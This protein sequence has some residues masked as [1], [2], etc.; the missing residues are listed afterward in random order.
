MQK[1]PMP[2]IVMSSL[3]PQGSDLALEALE[4]GAVDVLGKPYG[5]HSVALL[6]RQLAERLKT[7]VR[8]R[9]RPSAALAPC[10]KFEGPKGPS[11]IRGYRFHPRQLIVLGA[12][13]GGTEALRHV[14]ARLPGDLPPIAIV[15]HIPAGFS[16]TFAERLDSLCRM[17]VREAVQGEPLLPGTALVAPGDFH[18]L[19][20][21]AGRRYEV[22]LRQGPPV[23]HQRPAVDVLFKSAAE[24]SGKRC[25]AGVLTGMGRDGADGLLRLRSTGAMTLAQDEASCVVYGMP[26]AAFEAGAVQRVVS[27]DAFPAAILDAL[28]DDSAGS[29]SGAQRSEPPSPSG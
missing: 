6:G 17:E 13:T 18:M 16:R 3:T 28:Q 2:V 12:S 23:W 9:V 22:A 21:W 11:T 15:Q 4:A 1:I 5:S 25:V 8:C 7:A 29:A 10:A 20:T 24:A 19:T 14:L 26:K 27:L